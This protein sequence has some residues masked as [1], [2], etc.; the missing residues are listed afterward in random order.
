MNSQS[1]IHFSHFDVGLESAIRGLDNPHDKI[2][3]AVTALATHLNAFCFVAGAPR[4]GDQPER[5]CPLPLSAE[6]T[7]PDGNTLS[8]FCSRRGKEKEPKK[9]IYEVSVWGSWTLIIKADSNSWKDS[10]CPKQMGERVKAILEQEMSSPP[11]LPFAPL[12]ISKKM[13]LAEEDIKLILS[14]LQA[15]QKY[16]SPLFQ[17]FDLIALAEKLPQQRQKMRW[18]WITQR[19]GTSGKHPFIYLF[20]E[21]GKKESSLHLANPDESAG[22]IHHILADKTSRI[23]WDYPNDPDWKIPK[24]Q[25]EQ[26]C[27]LA[28]ANLYPHLVYVPVSGR[29]ALQISFG[30]GDNPPNLLTFANKFRELAPVA[31]LSA[32]QESLQTEVMKLFADNPGLNLFSRQTNGLAESEVRRILRLLLELYPVPSMAVAE[33]RMALIPDDSH[34]HFS[35]HAAKYATVTLQQT[36]QFIRAQSQTEQYRRYGATALGV[37]H[38]IC[39]PIHFMQEFVKLVDAHPFAETDPLRFESKKMQSFLDKV[40]VFTA[41][42]FKNLEALSKQLSGA[43]G[44]SSKCDAKQVI[45]ILTTVKFLTL[46]V[47]PG[48]TSKKDAPLRFCEPSQGIRVLVITVDGCSYDAPAETLA[49][50]IAELIANAADFVSKQRDLKNT[51][52][53]V[54]ITFGNDA[55]TVS[56]SIGSNANND[57]VSRIR[58]AMET[59]GKSVH[60]VIQLANVVGFSFA[61]PEVVDSKCVLRIQKGSA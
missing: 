3:A 55:I 9:N 15:C 54:W 28:Q 34:D 14:D 43:H 17:A 22:I 10:P 46:L 45:E 53:H 13:N 4:T 47:D 50:V 59:W 42:D 7:S 36:I 60:K 38:T 23:V 49:L 18:A 41:L 16:M 24:K 19:S 39:R 58:A 35:S 37:K 56:N 1:D 52:P 57:V 48:G 20:A 21:V 12:S 44:T 6:I 8:K 51:D 40:S 61:P 2:A 25:R 26:F 31:I 32:F 33:N 27:T 29:L 5:N 11:V 30:T